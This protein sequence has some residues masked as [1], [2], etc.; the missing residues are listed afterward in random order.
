MHYVDPT[1]ESDFYADKPWALLVPPL[2]P[3]ASSSFQKLIV[4]CL[5][6]DSQHLSSPLVSTTPYLAIEP[7]PSTSSLPKFSSNDLKPLKENSLDGIVAN[8]KRSGANDEAEELESED[9][10]EESWALNGTA[11]KAWVNVKDNRKRLKITKEVSL[12]D[13]ELREWEEMR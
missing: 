5:L 10:D 2:P 11:R 1:M 4:L 9:V 13:H 12:F 7:L 6:I 8:L 3:R